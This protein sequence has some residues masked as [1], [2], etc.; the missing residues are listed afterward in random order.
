MIAASSL[1]FTVAVAKISLTLPLAAWRTRAGARSLVVAVGGVAVVVAGLMMQDRSG[2]VLDGL[3]AF[4]RMDAQDGGLAPSDSADW[5]EGI[6]L[7]AARRKEDVFVSSDLDE[8]DD[9]VG[10]TGTSCAG[11]F[12][13]SQM[14]CCWWC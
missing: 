1:S 5:S 8:E 11:R 2:K 4:S 7:E 10:E 13:D 14:T 6:F 3:A 12:L 9:D